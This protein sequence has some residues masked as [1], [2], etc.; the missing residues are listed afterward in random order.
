MDNPNCEL[1]NAP[2]PDHDQYFKICASCLVTFPGNEICK[3]AIIKIAK[4]TAKNQCKGLMNELKAT[5]DTIASLTQI[6]ECQQQII[7]NVTTVEESLGKE[8]I[9]IKSIIEEQEHKQSLEDALSHVQN[10]VKVMQ[11]KIQN[12]ESSQFSSSVAVNTICE[13]QF[14]E[15]RACD[16]DRY[17]L[18]KTI[19]FNVIHKLGINRDDGISRNW[20]VFFRFYVSFI[21]LVRIV[22]LVPFSVPIHCHVLLVILF[23]S[24]EILLLRLPIVSTSPGDVQRQLVTFQTRHTMETIYVRSFVYVLSLWRKGFS[25]Q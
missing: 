4:D 16:V 15:V 5:H 6:N 19:M 24:G 12:Q 8:I 7:Q 25:H 21:L 9:Q 23:P 18:G 1:C 20:N 17:G 22:V 14:K 13:S 11:D 2:H 10:V 3:K